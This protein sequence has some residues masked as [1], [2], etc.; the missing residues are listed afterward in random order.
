MKIIAVNG[1]PRKN[2]NTAVLLQ[3]ALR[4][5][6]ANNAGTRMINLYDL[7]FKGCISCFVCKKKGNRCNGLC[8]V[9]D[10]LTEVLKDILACDVLIIGS[11]IYFGNVTGEIRSF[12]E[13]LLFPNLS[14]NEGERSVFPGKLASAFIYTMNVPEDV[15]HQINYDAIFQQNRH[16]LNIISED[17]EVLLSCDT[18]QF[19]DYSGYEASGFDEAHKAKVRERQF[20]VDCQKAFDM[21]ARLTMAGKKD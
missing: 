16:L 2:G 6:E 18:Y 19:S 7:D 21:G 9:R 14:Y 10:D 11:P 8:A 17:P 20:P 5:A 1:S 3:N 13:R 4:G 12:L 15:M